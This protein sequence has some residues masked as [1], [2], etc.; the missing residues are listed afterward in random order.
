MKFLLL[1]ITVNFQ[2]STVNCLFAQWY[3][4][5]SGMTTGAFYGVDFVDVY[6]GYAVGLYKVIVKTTNGGVN[7]I[8]LSRDTT[9]Y[10]PLVGV[11]FVNANTGT[12]VGQL[13]QGGQNAILRTTNGGLTWVSQYGTLG[14]TGVS[15]VNAN[16]GLISGSGGVLRTT[17]GGDNWV[18]IGGISGLNAVQLVDTNLAF[19]VG[20]TFQYSWNIYR[21]TNGGLNWQEIGTSNSNDLYGVSFAN[22]STGIVVGDF[23]SIY[24]TTSGGNVWSR[25]GQ[26]LPGAYPYRGVSMSDINNATVV[27]AGGR[28]VR[29]TNGGFNWF[30]ENSGTTNHLQAV[31]MV[32]SLNGWAV[33]TYGTI[34]HTTNGGITSAVGQE[35]NIPENFHLEQNYPNPFNTSSKFKVQSSKSGKVRIEV[36][37][38]AGKL[39]TT[40]FNGELAAGLHEFEFD[41]T[42]LPSGVYFYRL[43]TRD[44]IQ[45]RRLVL[46]K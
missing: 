37:D 1:I 35:N 36:F 34:L 21:S 12:V 45:T 8:L 30:V 33:G 42:N 26:E 6:T 9:W 27:G 31:I 7:W 24:L 44:I 18:Y 25:K 2:L 15:F 41:G 23:G 38:A 20:S 19:A 3:Q 40:L 22:P 11:D 43:T 29:T 46:L 39:V 32:D 16:S 28:I 5:N 4:Q 17:N 13:G 10:N 14:S